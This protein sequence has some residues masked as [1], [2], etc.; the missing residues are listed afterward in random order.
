M[1]FSISLSSNLKQ[2]KIEKKN[3]K[4]KICSESGEMKIKRDGDKSDSDKDEDEVEK[5][6]QQ[7]EKLWIDDPD[8]AMIPF[9]W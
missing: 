8:E 3:Y 7:R 2:Q 4:I 6:P 1:L 9:Y 5:K